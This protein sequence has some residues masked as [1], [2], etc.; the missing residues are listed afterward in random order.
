MP[1]VVENKENTLVE[2]VL[3]N[4]K[5]VVR[6]TKSGLI[7][8]KTDGLTNPEMAKKYNLTPASI[9]KALRMVGLTNK[10][11]KPKAKFEVTED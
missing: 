3:A 7:K 1:E 5:T 4:A 6:L 8:D 11:A 2:P 10:R 9:S